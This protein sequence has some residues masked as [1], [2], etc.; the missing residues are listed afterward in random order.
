MRFIAAHTS[1]PVPKVYCA[2][3]R[4]GWIYIMM[5]RIDGDMIARRWVYRSVESKAKSLSQ[6]KQMV[7]KHAEHPACT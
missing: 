2:F 5:E 3:T 4:H 1:I 6:V 7:Q